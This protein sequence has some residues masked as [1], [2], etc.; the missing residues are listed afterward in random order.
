VV[1]FVFHIIISENFAK[2]LSVL[3]D[4]ATKHPALRDGYLAKSQTAAQKFDVI[5]DAVQ[6]QR[7]L[8]DLKSVMNKVETQLKLIKECKYNLLNCNLFN[9]S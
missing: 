8:E 4:L 3:T 2:R 6:V 9:I 7:H 1:I 5:T